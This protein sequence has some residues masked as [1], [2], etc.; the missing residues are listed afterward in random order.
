MQEPA[1]KPKVEI[2]LSQRAE[3]PPSP[4]GAPAPSNMSP[5]PPQSPPTTA[6][7]KDGAPIQGQVDTREPAQRKDFEDKK[8]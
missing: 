6:E 1:N 7:R 4:S 8:R 2:P 3:L 5:A